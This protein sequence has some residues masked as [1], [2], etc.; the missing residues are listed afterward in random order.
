MFRIRRIYDHVLP[1]NAEAVRQV[2]AIIGLQFPAVPVGEVDKLAEKLRDPVKFRF[3]SLLLVADDWQGKVQGFALVMHEPRLGFCFLDFISAG[4]RLEGRGVGGALY[5]RVRE[6]AK[7]MGVIGVFFECLP[8]DPALSRDPDVRRKNASRLRFYERFGARPI[9]GT[10]YE[11]PVT[12]GG[13]NPPYLVF[14]DLGQ[15]MPLHRDTARA[16]VRAILEGKYAKLC[17]PEYVKMVVESFTDDP[18]RLR[19]PR[20]IKQQTAAITV[21]GPRS[22]D[23]RIVLVVNDR[24]HIHHVH[25]RGYVESP[26]RINSILRELE[27]VDLFLRVSPRHFGEKHILDVHDP[28]FVSYFKRVCEDLP[29]GKSIYPYVFPI[30]NGA[31]PPKE[32]AVRAGYYCIDTFTPLNRNAFLAAK[33]AVDSALTAAEEI[34]HG[35]RLAYALVRP[36]GHHAERRTFG[37]FCYFNSTAVAAHYLSALGKVAILDVDYH[38]GNGQQDIFYSRG[39]VLTISIHG[40]PHFAYPYF[41]GFEEERGEGAGLGAN[42]NLPQAEHL[43]GDGHRKAL[44]TA[45]RRIRQFAP[46][47]LVVAFGL[48]TAKGDPTGSWSLRAR[49]FEANGQMIGSIGLP[50]LVVQEGG[51]DN[52]VIGSNARNFFQ[53]L[54]FAHD[55]QA[56]AAPRT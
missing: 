37:G 35:A 38:H 42:V 15:G 53:G 32:L 18:V 9:A 39:D 23:R 30:R 33:R 5:Q 2:Q 6:E 49:D 25:E 24:H 3:R 45:V 10:K 52:R 51:Y 48:D 12:P 56:V 36:P 55:K 7:S 22:P 50:T 13:D 29:P 34:L 17:P 28:S 46:Q 14:D 26:V 40:H 41:S 31:R 20:Y 16:I 19:E 21:A 27:R 11:T 44:A 8:D 47:F 4:P 54:W 1:I 43:D